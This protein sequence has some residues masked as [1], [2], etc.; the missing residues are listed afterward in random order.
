MWSELLYCTESHSNMLCLC[1]VCSSIP[2]HCSAGYHLAGRRRFVQTL[3]PRESCSCR[4]GSPGLAATPWTESGRNFTR[5]LAFHK[6]YC[7]DF[8][9]IYF[10][11]LDFYFINVIGVFSDF[12]VISWSDQAPLSSFSSL[13]QKHLFK[14]NFASIMSARLFHEKKTF[15]IKLCFLEMKLNEI[16]SHL[17]KYSAEM[18][19]RNQDSFG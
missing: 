19:A 18:H 8:A 6:F 14:S 1:Y 7:P 15:Q 17:I 3:I 9:W 16:Q 2:S 10:K 12:T 13:R 5:W 4:Y 11:C